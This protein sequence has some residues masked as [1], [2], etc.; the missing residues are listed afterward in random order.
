MDRD[1]GLEEVLSA[2]DLEHF[3]AELGEHPQP[4]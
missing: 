1:G 3:C 2:D 4:G